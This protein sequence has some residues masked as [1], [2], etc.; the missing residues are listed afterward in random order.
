MIEDSILTNPIPLLAIKNPKLIKKI[1]AYLPYSSAFE[2]ECDKGKNFDVQN[3]WDI[4]NIMDVNCD[5]YEQRFRVPAGL[6]GLVCLWYI[7]EQLKLNSELNVLSGIHY[8]C[9]CTDV[10]H[11][12][13]NKH[14]EDGQ[15]WILEELETWSP[16]YT[17]KKS[18]GWLKFNDLH[19]LEFRVGEMTFDYP[20]LA[21][22][23]IHCND[24]TRRFKLSVL[25]GQSKLELENLH[26][27]LKELEVVEESPIYRDV[28]EEV[29]KT[30][31]QRV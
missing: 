17:A 7:A 1:D 29:V 6:K 14:R 24:M 13:T 3:F 20:I 5:S 26:K 28:A 27:K 12:L 22:R 2:V 11:L 19:T 10:W 9:D 8:H 25:E 15:K 18:R 4:P 30:R 16:E 21:K 23:M 31:I